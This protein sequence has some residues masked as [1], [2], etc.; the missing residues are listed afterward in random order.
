MVVVVAI[1][2]AVVATLMFAGISLWLV[3]AA[4]REPHITSEEE[5]RAS[6]QSLPWPSDAD[7]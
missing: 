3:I 7:L 5:E 6:M 1:V 4:I 2:L